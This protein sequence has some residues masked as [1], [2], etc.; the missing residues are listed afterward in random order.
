MVFLEVSIEA[1]DFSKDKEEFSRVISFAVT[2]MVR[3]ERSGDGMIYF[4]NP[5]ALGA[6]K[7]P[8]GRP[9]PQGKNE[10]K[11]TMSY[12][13]K[14]RR[15]SRKMVTFFFGAVD[16]CAKIVMDGLRR[17]LG[18]AWRWIGPHRRQMGDVAMTAD[19][20]RELI[21]Y[22]S[23]KSETD[24]PFG[25]TKLN[26]ILFYSDFAA[27][28]RRRKAITGQTYFKLTEGP[29]PRCMKPLIRDMI[30]DG[31]LRIDRRAFHRWRQKR[32]VALREAR[33][34]GFTAEE[35]AIV[36]A[37]IRKFWGLS[38]RQVSDLSHG[39][40]GWKL[41]E[42]EED[43]PYCMAFSVPVGALTEGERSQGESL[44]ASIDVIRSSLQ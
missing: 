12:A 8:T 39:F 13:R 15:Y 30:A 5:H 2:W 24:L 31:D 16:V 21:L 3:A 27:Y 14:K 28:Q 25:A 35:L 43:I 38:A 41:A 34:D 36:D 17:S 10:Q 37:Y 6:V 1:G 7:N 29:A 44:R 22:I 23:R 20:M 42:T 19:K 33:L 9:M 11:P 40:I 18:S 26:K 4:A 32:P